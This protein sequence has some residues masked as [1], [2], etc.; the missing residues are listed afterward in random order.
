MW[1]PIS[2]PVIILAIV[3]TLQPQQMVCN[4]KVVLSTR[5]ALKTLN[6]SHVLNMRYI[7]V[8]TKKIK[9]PIA[10]LKCPVSCL[11]P[12][13]YSHTKIKVMIIKNPFSMLTIT[14]IMPFNRIRLW[15][16]LWIPINS[17]A[18]YAKHINNEI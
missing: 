15:V 12:N 8:A 2:I 16:F 7:I 14:L 18:R 13:P 4:E 17:K 3:K 9:K 1:K 11:L 5:F 6:W 10:I